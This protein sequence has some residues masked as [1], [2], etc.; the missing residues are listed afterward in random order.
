MDDPKEDI[1]HR[2]GFRISELD[3]R[4]GDWRLRKR[5]RF[6]V[7]R[8]CALYV[9]LSEKSYPKN[10]RPLE[11]PSNADA[12][13]IGFKSGA[14]RTGVFVAEGQMTADEIADRLNPAPAA[15]A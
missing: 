11:E 3:L 12:L 14:G 4:G 9:C 2:L 5:D 1:V 15:R 10:L 13:L 8:S 6:K 7:K